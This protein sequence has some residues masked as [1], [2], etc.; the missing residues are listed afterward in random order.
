MRARKCLHV[1]LQDNAFVQ[2]LRAHLYESADTRVDEDIDTSKHWYPDG[3]PSSPFLWFTYQRVVLYRIH[4]VAKPYH[5]S[6]KHY[7]FRA[8]NF[9]LWNLEEPERNLIERFDVFISFLTLSSIFSERFVRQNNYFI[10]FYSKHILIQ[11]S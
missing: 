11:E 4:Y 1:M 8:N 2:K 9:Q 3:V 6:V 10:I 5:D 7:S